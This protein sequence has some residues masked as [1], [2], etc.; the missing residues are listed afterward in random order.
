MKTDTPPS[1]DNYDAFLAR[2]DAATTSLSTRAASLDK[3]LAAVSLLL[4]PYES[5]VRNWERRRIHVREQLARHSG[6]PQSYTALGELHEVAVNMETMFRDRAR[7]IRDTLSVM[8]GRREAIDKSLLE[9]ELSR[10]KLNSSRLLAE[11]RER[12]SSVFTALAGSAVA[13]SALPDRG[14]L[15]DLKEARKAVILAEAL[16]EVK[17]Y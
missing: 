11:D 2:L 6:P 12:L 9:L 16:M 17:G 5:A 1:P 8:Q 4:S 10:V 13:T 7:R 3:A 15:S 14:L